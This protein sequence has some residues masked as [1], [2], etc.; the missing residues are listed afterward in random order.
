MERGC[1]ASV[2]PIRSVICALVN[3]T[4]FIAACLPLA[5]LTSCGR[6]H[7]ADPPT[8]AAVPA[9][10]VV[11][12]D[13]ARNACGLSRPGDANSKSMPCIEVTSYLVKTLKLPRGSLFDYKTIPDVNVAEFDLVMSELKAA[14]Y[15]LTPGTHAGFLT[16]P[17]PPHP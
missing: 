12:F 7:P 1:E 10:V 5:F 17:K 15:K 8:V 3:R 16:E 14:G 6:S 4:L 2:A 9:E 11:T 13:G